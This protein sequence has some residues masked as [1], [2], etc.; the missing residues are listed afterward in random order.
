MNKVKHMTK[1]RKVLR[2]TSEVIAA[3]GGTAKAA[4][5][6]DVTSAAVSQ[7]RQDGIPSGYHYRMA[8]DLETAGHIVDGK[9][10]GWR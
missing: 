1:R 2:T 9:S 10:L 6:W 8:A 5:R 4:Q 3:Y 7:W